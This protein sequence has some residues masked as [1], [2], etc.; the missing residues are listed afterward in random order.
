[1]SYS[2]DWIKAKTL[3]KKFT[4]WH[5]IWCCANVKR[6]Q[7]DPPPSTCFKEPFAGEQYVRA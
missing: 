4:K 2:C 5:C 6:L 7:K 1:M 3:S